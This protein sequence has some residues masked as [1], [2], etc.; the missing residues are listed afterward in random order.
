MKKKK[1]HLRIKST[2]AHFHIS[3]S[4]N[5]KSN[6][7]TLSLTTHPLHP[8]A[9]SQAVITVENA[10]FTVL[11]SRLI[12]LEWASDGGFQDFASFVF[13]NRLLP[14]PDFRVEEQDGW[15][16]IRTEF[17][18]LRYR[19]GLGMFA[20]E[21]LNIEFELN[22]IKKIWHPGME[23][24]GNLRG[25]TRTLDRIK[26]SIPLEPGVISRD[27]WVLIN[28][29]EGPL[30]DH[31]QEW[32]WVMP[33][34]DKPQQDWYFFGFGHDYRA[35]L[36]AFV[37][38]SGKIPL[39]PRYTF[40][41]WW[42]RYWP[43]TDEDFRQLIDEFEIHDVPL[44][45]LIID[46]DWHLNFKEDWLKNKLDQAGEK[47]G[48]TGFTWNR[49]FFPEPEK[50][51][52]WL[53][54]KGL[55]VSMNLHPASGV[56]PH[57]EQ[58]EAMATAMGIDPATE[59]YVPFDIVDRKFTDNYFKILLHPFE[60]WGVDFW[61]LDWQQWST[62]KIKGVTP[63]FWLNY[64]HF[65]DMERRSK[66]RPLIFHRW[67]G[68]GNHRYPVGFSGD[69]YIDWKSLSF[70]PYFTATAANVG[71]GYWSHDIGGH[72]KG[73][74]TP[75]LYTRWIQFG[76]FSPMFRT[77]ASNNPRIERRIWAYPVDY[78]YAMRDAIHLRYSLIPYLYTMGRKAYDSGISI[79]YPTYYD[80]P[81]HPEAYIHKDQYM[82]GESMLVSPIVK[83]IEEDYLAVW[84][85]TWLPPGKW[86][87]WFSGATLKGGTTVTRDYTI[88]EIPL[89]VKAG[90]IIPLQPPRRKADGLASETMILAV[91]PGESGS[92]AVYE[93]EGD[94]IGYTQNICAFTPVHFFRENDVYHIEI[95]P[96]EGEYPGMASERSYELRLMHVFLPNE[97]RLNGE[98][99][100]HVRALYVEE[101]PEACYFYDGNEMATIIR[102][103]A[104]SVREKLEI[105]VE[106]D[107]LH[108]AELLDGAKGKINWLKR[109]RRE[110]NAKY[111]EY[112]EWV[113]D[114]LIEAC[115]TGTR[116]SQHPENMA[117]ELEKLKEMLPRILDK[118][119]ELTDNN[120]VFDPAL[121]LL[122]DLEK[123]YFFHE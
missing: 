37:D 84:Q 82:F 52:K 28:D 120:P 15:L 101:H 93:D 110:L 64:V 111:N 70:Q 85:T 86:I 24:T 57:E 41:Y 42:S 49:T 105:R 34:P 121:K 38:V 40:G 114:V 96:A 16:I 91:F 95:A 116:I 31:R 51:I 55:R 12:R 113:P 30:Y 4:K 75:E 66:N 94:S 68:L 23:D 21:N 32:A 62:T 14:V 36:Q 99:L 8:L 79:C 119:E 44:D 81:E 63:T 54:R 118:V 98:V 48:W 5:R 80:F 35:A 29:S 6:M 90:A 61:W 20:K 13:I 77:H 39:P 9:D 78:F 11:T 67:G 46:M 107:T 103:P 83:H 60:E 50:F 56:Q 27:G 53:R 117:E 45:V 25:T 33:R 104:N 7:E 112:Q 59:K 73:I 26:G 87:E 19:Q 88:E 10:R 58:Y 71:F 18:Q 69:T 100:P 115:Q 17:L 109:V 92:V 76:I 43:Y 3:T 1:L 22:G 108:P 123:Q 97:I 72:Y 89:F 122:R 2:S 47:K 74:S 102:L 106:L 65:S